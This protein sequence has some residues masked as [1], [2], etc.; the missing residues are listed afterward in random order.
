M[1]KYRLM[2]LLPNHRLNESL[3]YSDSDD[4]SFSMIILLLDFHKR[5][6]PVLIEKIELSIIHEI[7]IILL[8]AYTVACI[9]VSFMTS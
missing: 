7:R 8:Y 9:S 1:S 4:F 5:K 3:N 6:S 2:N